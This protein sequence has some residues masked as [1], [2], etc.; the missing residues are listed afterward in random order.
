MPWCSTIRDRLTPIRFRKLM[1]HSCLLSRQRYAHFLD[2]VMRSAT[3]VLDGIISF[4][5]WDSTWHLRPAITGSDNQQKPWSKNYRDSLS[6]ILGLGNWGG[7]WLPEKTESGEVVM[8]YRT[9][10][11]ESIRFYAGTRIILSQIYS[12]GRYIRTTLA[13]SINRL[14]RSLE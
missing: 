11:L 3:G 1:G 5:N 4:R 13:I 2:Q 8:L 9:L 10:L 7:N 6:R 12:L 14:L